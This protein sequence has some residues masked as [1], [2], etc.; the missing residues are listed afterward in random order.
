MTPR[1]A[2]ALRRPLDAPDTPVAPYRHVEPQSDG[3]LLVTILAVDR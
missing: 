2:L 1:Q 3:N